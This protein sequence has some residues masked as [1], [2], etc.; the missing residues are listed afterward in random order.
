MAIPL[1]RRIDLSSATLPHE[2]LKHDYASSDISLGKGPGSLHSVDM[3]GFGLC[4]PDDLAHGGL[5]P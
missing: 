3:A 2:R 4:G 1:M 5:S